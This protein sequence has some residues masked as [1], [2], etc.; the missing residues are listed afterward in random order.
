MEYRNAISF[1]LKSPDHRGRLSRKAQS[2]RLGQL[3]LTPILACCGTDPQQALLFTD[4]QDLAFLPFLISAIQI[5]RTFSPRGHNFKQLSRYASTVSRSPCSMSSLASTS[6]GPDK[7]MSG[8]AAGFA[9][10]SKYCLA[11]ARSPVRSAMRP[12][13]VFARCTAGRSELLR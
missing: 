8:A 10:S 5:R 6:V 1:F 13:I 9:E 12:R 7:A 2:T 11:S 4:H 3:T